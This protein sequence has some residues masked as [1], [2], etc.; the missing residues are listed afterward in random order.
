MTRIKGVILS[1]E[2]TICPNGTLDEAIFSEVDKLIN[3]FKSKNI[4]FVVHTNRSWTYNKTN[5]LE[6]E[7]GGF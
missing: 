6:G 3:Y 5:K 2:G 1:V 4:E 7:M